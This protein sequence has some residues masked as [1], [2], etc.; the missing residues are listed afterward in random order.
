M[1]LTI[2]IISIVKM[3]SNKFDPTDIIRPLPS[4]LL[5]PPRNVPFK[6]GDIITLQSTTNSCSSIQS[7]L[8]DCYNRQLGSTCGIVKSGTSSNGTRYSFRRGPGGNTFCLE[9]ASIPNVYLYLKDVRDCMPGEALC[10]RTTH[11][12]GQECQPQFAF[13]IIAKKDYSNNNNTQLVALQ[14]LVNSSVFLSLD[15]K[16][17]S[18]EINGSNNRQERCGILRGRY[19]E[20]SNRLKKGDYE[21]FMMIRAS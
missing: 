10:G 3:L 12:V 13:N 11:I 21:V 14:S 19:I 5:E 8:I 1:K 9:L 15:S 16:M 7:Q 2:L 4:Y 17:C 20:D 6:D 18:N